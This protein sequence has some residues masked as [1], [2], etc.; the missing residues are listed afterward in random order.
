MK[1][2]HVSLPVLTALAAYLTVGAGEA[3]ATTRLIS[4]SCDLAAERAAT[5]STVPLEVLRSISLVETGRS[6][7][8]EMQ[9]WPWTINY[10]GKGYWF[11]SSRQ[12]I[13]FGDGLLAK[14]ITNFDVGCFQVNLRWHPNA[15]ESLADAFDPS[16]NA[17]YAASYLLEL[18]NLHGEW[19]KAVS[20]YHSRAEAKGYAYLKKVQTAL[21]LIREVEPLEGMA[22]EYEP[23]SA[24]NNYP[25]LFTASPPLGPSLFSSTFENRPLFELVR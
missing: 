8:G 23:E 3:S 10:D 2:F 6:V 9:S 11:E 24:R 5:T 17:S 1:Y 21:D 18:L 4:G 19:P 14:G 25:L 15:F 13:D 7:S 12:A 16:E 20:S 22:A